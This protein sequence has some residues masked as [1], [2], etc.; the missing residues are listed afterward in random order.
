MQSDT[1]FAKGTLNYSELD[2]ACFYIMNIGLWAKL[3]SS[4][5]L[6]DWLRLDGRTSVDDVGRTAVTARGYKLQAKSH[7]IKLP[8]VRVMGCTL[9]IHHSPYDFAA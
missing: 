4:N 8:R 3:R 9:K 5:V 6:A 2:T 7:A 1:R